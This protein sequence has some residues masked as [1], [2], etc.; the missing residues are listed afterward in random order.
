MSWALA[1][2]RGLL[3]F[4]LSPSAILPD[5]NRPVAARRRTVAVLAVF[6]FLLNILIQPLLELLIDA[7][8]AQSQ[9]DQVRPLDLVFWAVV[10]APVMEELIF[11]GW[12]RLP[13]ALPACLLGALA[14]YLPNDEYLLITFALFGAG[15]A[16]LAMRLAI[17]GDAVA[18]YQ[19][20]VADHFGQLVYA[21]SFVF[22][23]LHLLNWQSSDASTIAWLLLVIPQLIVGL[24]LAYVCRRDGLL[25]AIALHAGYNALVT[26]PA[27]LG[28]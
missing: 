9:L 1:E 23:L 4:L 21:S 10:V 24:A 22:A 20:W 17:S 14:L 27:L 13:I 3:T 5:P 28:A 11:R 25:Y 15:A 8:D 19:Q 16:F 12:M 26:L 18:R 6:M 2:L 7:Q